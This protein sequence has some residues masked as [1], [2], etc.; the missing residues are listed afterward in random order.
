MT[1]A[2]SSTGPR[3][4]RFTEVFLARLALGAAV[5]EVWEASASEVPGPERFREAADAGE[6]SY[7]LEEHMKW[8]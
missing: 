7:M 8:E 3:F 2:S 4:L 1:Y 5:S 6:S